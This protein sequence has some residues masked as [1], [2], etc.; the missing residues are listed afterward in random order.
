M[1]AQIIS[2]G[3]EDVVSHWRINGSLKCKVKS[4]STSVFAVA[5]NEASARNRV[6][7]FR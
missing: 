6:C 1:S 4:S 3:M 7:S 5:V 2:A